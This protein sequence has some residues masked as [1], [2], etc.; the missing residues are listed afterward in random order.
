MQL[1]YING[2]M[3]FTVR[4]DCVKSSIKN[5][6]YAKTMV[7]LRTDCNPQITTLVQRDWQSISHLIRTI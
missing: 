5:S 1:A 2:K 6:N 4:D 3:H 7:G